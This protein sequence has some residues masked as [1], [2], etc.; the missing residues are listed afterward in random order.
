MR[1]SRSA[2]I[3]ASLTFICNG[4]SWAVRKNSEVEGRPHVRFFHSADG[5]ER[6]RLPT[7]ALQQVGSYLGYAGYQIDVVVTAARDPTPIL[8]SRF[9]S[10]GCTL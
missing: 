4:C 9:R 3:R 5:A 1:A 2:A 8:R 6:T 10:G 7:C